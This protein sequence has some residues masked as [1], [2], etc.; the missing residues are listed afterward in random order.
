MNVENLSIDLP[1]GFD[2]SKPLQIE[3]IDREGTAPEINE[4]KLFE[5]VVAVGSVVPFVRFRER[6]SPEAQDALRRTGVFIYSINPDKPLLQFLANPEDK[7][8]FSLLALLEIDPDFAAFAINTDRTFNAKA[9]EALIMKRAHC[10][11][12]EEI[13]KGLLANLRNFEVKFEQFVEKADDRQGNK[14]DAHSEALKFTKG[15]MPKEFHLSLP[16]WKHTL[17]QEL[18]LEIQIDKGPGNMPV[19]SFY[20]MD[21]DLRQREV[22]EA[23]IRMEINAISQDY[24]TLE[25]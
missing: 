10:F 24:A 18:V 14:K 21:A 1:D 12:S 19:Y 25:V 3:I 11:A 8:A 13:A 9:M 20:S 6:Y 17:K 23:V 22:A 15:E 4:P 5:K 7:R 2:Q 16:I